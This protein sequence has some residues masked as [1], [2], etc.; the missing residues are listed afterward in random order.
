VCQEWSEVAQDTGRRKIAIVG[1]GGMDIR[2]EHQDV[3]S[4]DWSNL[5][6][7]GTLRDYDGIVVTLTEGV[8]D[9]QLAELAQMLAGG[10][11]RSVLEH[12]GAIYVLGDPRRNIGLPKP[13]PFLTWT[14]LDFDWIDGAGDTVNLASDSAE[15]GG[16]LRSLSSWTYSLKSV[17][18]A[19]PTTWTT[20]TPKALRWSVRSRP[21][22]KNRFGGYL[23]SHITL[24][25]EQL[26]QHRTTTYWDA[27]SGTLTGPLV[28]LPFTQLSPKDSVATLLRDVFEVVYDTPAP[29][30]INSVTMPS[31]V[32]ELDHQLA[33]VAREAE[34]LRAREQA[35]KVARTAAA[36]PLTLLYGQGEDLEVAVRHALSRLGAEVEEPT[37][38]GKEDGWIRVTVNGRTEQAVLEIKSTRKDS[39]DEGG[40]RQLL[41]WQVRGIADRQIRYK[42]LFIGNPGAD[43]APRDRK[44]PFSQSWIN[45]ARLGDIAALLTE[46]LFR[47]VLLHERGELEL[48]GFWSAIF[49][50]AGPINTAEIR[51]RQRLQA[52]AP[53]N[54]GS[55]SSGTSHHAAG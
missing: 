8:T 33:T 53:A 36:Q 9:A 45:T 12:G 17:K 47:A 29:S 48:D 50:A 7:F 27:K 30:W 13:A 43:K 1:L 24:Y 28:L 49:S 32:L 10:V 11:C 35:L 19:D 40:V 5:R 2:G 14:G 23:A 21:L 18:L 31:T 52:D 46:D 38:P 16:Y 55:A 3:R 22:A 37:N 20:A 39:F 15:I 44:Q 41:E 25:L 51:V 6:R 4:H 54:T 26:K 42:P 34:E